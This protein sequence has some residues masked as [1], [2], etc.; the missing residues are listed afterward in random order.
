MRGSERK[1][2]NHK[3]IESHK[4]RGHWLA[5]LIVALCIIGGSS[6]TASHEERRVA[7]LK[8]GV[9][10]FAIPELRDPNFLHSVVLLINYEKA[11]A[12]G[13]IINRPTEIPLDQALPNVEGIEGLS[14]PLF[15]GGPVNRNL[16]LGLLNSKKPLQAAQKV[17]DHIYF[18]RNRGT[19]IDAL[20]T[21]NPDKEV[22][23]Y[24][25]YA[26]WAPG[27]LEREVSRGDWLISNADPEMIFSK[28]PSQIWPEIFKIQ[29]QIEIHERPFDRTPHRKEN[30]RHRRA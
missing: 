10:L 19:L 23:V 24:A 22:R 14:L 11:G 25:G 27:Q 9:F 20:R 4:R 8:Q 2:A 7:R 26:G 13:L 21:F 12:T 28:D 29:E 16:L 6:A 15:F 1:R 5:A 30:S 18:T 3:E 17:F